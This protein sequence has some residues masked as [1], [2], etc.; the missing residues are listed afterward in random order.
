M[1]EG[2]EEEGTTPASSSS[3]ATAPEAPTAASPMTAVQAVEGAEGSTVS[4]TFHVPPL[5]QHSRQHNS[6]P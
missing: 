3:R 6:D 4:R 2:A 5:T 1:E